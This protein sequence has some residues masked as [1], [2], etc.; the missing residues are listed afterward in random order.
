MLFHSTSTLDTSQIQRSFRLD[1][2]P[3]PTEAQPASSKRSEQLFQSLFFSEILPSLQIEDKASTISGYKTA[4]THFCDWFDS[5]KT[6]PETGDSSMRAKHNLRSQGPKVVDLENRPT[7]LAQFYVFSL[8]K[9]A[10]TAAN[11]LKSLRT[12]W[13]R[14]F[15]G[16]HLRKP[17]P[18][19]RTRLIRKQ[20]QIETHKPVPIPVS[21][22]E[23][24]LLLTSV[25]EIADQLTWPTIGRLECWQFWWNVIAVCSVHGFRPGDIWP[26]EAKHGQGLLW[27]EI[28]P[29][30]S[31]PIPGGTH[32]RLQADWEFGWLKKR[33]NKTGETLIA[34][35]SPHLRWLVEQCRGLDP[36]RVFPIPYNGKFWDREFSKIRTTAN[37][38][39]V[40]LCDGAPSASLRKTASVLWKRAVNRSASSHMLC[41]AIDVG[42]QASEIT[43]RHYSGADILREIVEGYPALLASLPSLIRC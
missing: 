38:P 4:V 41:H 20:Q 36:V 37:L 21:N 26:R 31:P 11:K 35:M 25:I 10:K 8:K 13:R 14:L 17:L 19:L 30:A 43:E 39:H 7:L 16:G 27:S 32:E 24:D 18:E 33:T 9:G 28:F 40:S 3:E 5:L 42:D 23:I 2:E 6:P 22:A 34:P 29:S 15:A 12:I 1:D